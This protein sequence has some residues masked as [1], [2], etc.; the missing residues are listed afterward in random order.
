MAIGVRTR[1]LLL[2]VPA[3]FLGVLFAWPVVAIV[4]TGLRR[5][6]RLAVRRRPRRLG[7]HADTLAFTTWQAALSTALTFA[8]ALPG[9]VGAR[10][11]AV[12]RPSLVRALVVLPFVLPTV[13]V[14]TAVQGLVGPQGLLATWVALDESL[15]AIV[16]AH[17][18]FNYAVVVWIVGERWAHL[19]RRVEEAAT[20]LGAHRWAE[21]LRRVTFRCSRRRS[22]PRRCSCS[23]SLHQLR[24]RRAARRARARHHR[25]RHR[26]WWRRRS[27]TCRPPPRCPSLQLAA[28]ATLL[29]VHARLRDRS[30][31]TR[32]R[33]RCPHGPAAADPAAASGSPS[34]PC[35]ARSCCSSA[36][37]SWCSS[38]GRFRVGD[39]YGLDLVPAAV[40]VGGGLDPVRPAARRRPHLAAL[41]GVATVVAVVVGGL[42]AV[43][44]AARARPPRPRS[45]TLLSPSRSAPRP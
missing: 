5:R 14:A 17:A 9:G 29:A 21:V 44:V 31:T 8:V 18:F 45:P 33:P 25:G 42:A 32:P 35:S 40:G 10:P 2:V 12:P 30:S 38:S 27:S 43:A 3:V 20:M 6:R 41:R 37:R 13:V 28:V 1:L 4:A 19:D 11:V 22:W 23:S 34:S 36:P 16:L 39:G 26:P 15:L 24:R 7:A